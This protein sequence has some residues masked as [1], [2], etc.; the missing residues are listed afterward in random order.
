MSFASCNSS[1]SLRVLLK[2]TNM[3]TLIFVV[4]LVVLKLF[5]SSSALTHCVPVLSFFVPPV[6]S[7]LYPTPSAED[8][9]KHSSRNTIFITFPRYKLCHHGSF[10]SASFCFSCFST[11]P[12]SVV[13]CLSLEDFMCTAH[14]LVLA[15]PLRQCLHVL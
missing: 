9:D 8:G 11:C 10:T 12:E 3:S 15:Y 4:A 2:A 13:S 1:L 5:F 7:P 6:L 14:L